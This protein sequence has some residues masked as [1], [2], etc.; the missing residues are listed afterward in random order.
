VGTILLRVIFGGFW[1]LVATAGLVT[2][3]WAMTHGEAGPGL[4][5]LG[6]ALL[7]ATYAFYIFRGG[8]F[9]IIFW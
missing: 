8:R 9:L 5:V 2:S 3:G 4:L 7:C 6:A 1:S